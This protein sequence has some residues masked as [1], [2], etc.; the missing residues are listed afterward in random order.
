M[1]GVTEPGAMAGWL[2][3]PSA[4]IHARPTDYEYVRL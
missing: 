3:P 1:S 4:G 2:A